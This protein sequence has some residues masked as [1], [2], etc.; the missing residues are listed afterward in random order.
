MCGIIPYF[1]KINCYFMYIFILI[2]VC[3]GLFIF[4][5]LFKIPKIGNLCLV[6]GGVKAGKSMLSLHFAI[7]KYKRVLRGTKFV[8]FFRKIFKKE[9]LEI[10]LFY[11]NVPVGIP[12]VLI[13]DDI[14]MLKN[15]V[16]WG[17]VMY[18]QEASLFADSQLVKKDDI[19]ENLLLFNKLCAHFGLSLLM[20]DTQSISDLHYSIKR[21]LSNYFY[22][23]HNIKLPL[24]PFCVLYIQEYRYSEDNSLV[25]V[26]GVED[27]ENTLKRVIIPKSIWK[28]YNSTCFSKIVED[29]PVSADV[30][31]PTN[32]L[33]IDKII[34]FRDNYSKL[35]KPKNNDKKLIK[36]NISSEIE[37]FKNK[38]VKNNA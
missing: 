25:S 33:K 16:A 15:R 1:H 14:L 23:H 11:S 31:I 5:K 38:G 2:V 35:V 13:N 20:Y 7:K 30:I 26:S 37:K 32:D 12:Y 6:T 3:L 27:L 22:I 28:K 21:S 34:S 19:N 36:N 10:P 18:V 4:N 9:L 17:S 24:L 8:N 29:L